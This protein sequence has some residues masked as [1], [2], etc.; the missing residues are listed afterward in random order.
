MYGGFI[1]I[2]FLQLLLVRSFNLP[3]TS[4]IISDIQIVLEFISVNPKTAVIPSEINL[5]SRISSLSSN[6]PDVSD[7]YSLYWLSLEKIVAD[8]TEFAG[9]LSTLS[10]EIVS[11]VGSV[12]QILKS[13]SI[14]PAFN[15]DELQLHLDDL[16]KTLFFKIKIEFRNYL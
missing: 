1:I 13:G 4:A 12:V 10:D 3:S 8:N 11:T 2:F 5:L 15:L 14:V 9:K 6:A 16:S 7:F